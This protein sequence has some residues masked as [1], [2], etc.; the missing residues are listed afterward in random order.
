[1]HV[2][3]IVAVAFLFLTSLYLASWWASAFCALALIFLIWTRFF[4]KFILKRHFKNLKPL[5]ASPYHHL[6]PA[7]E[8]AFALN[9]NKKVD[10][11]VQPE[12]QRAE[13]YF[14]GD[15]KSGVIL[16]SEAC[17][18]HFNTKDLE[19]LSSRA[20]QLYGKNWLHFKQPLVSIFL[21]LSSL[22]RNLDTVIS[23]TFGLK[24][25]NGEPRPITRRG[26]YFLIHQLNSS[27]SFKNQSSALHPAQFYSYVV[28]RPSNPI[29]SPLSLIE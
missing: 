27:F 11:F 17:L 10:F 3:F 21:I 7:V 8:K 16:F 14:F 9:C 5:K 25:N 26:A 22:G 4:S 19:S 20:G 12:T 1:M 23:F 6:L 28:G 15:S 2:L 24:T 13:A 29:L 18:R